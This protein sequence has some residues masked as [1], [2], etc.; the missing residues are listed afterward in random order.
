MTQGDETHESDPEKLK[1][2]R[3]R[4]KTLRQQLQAELMRRNELIVSMVDDGYPQGSVASWAGVQRSTITH[5]LANPGMPTLFT[6][7]LTDQ[8]PA[9]RRGVGSRGAG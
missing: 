8:R 4:I 5:V 9:S 7:E 3:D 1:K 2:T 6:P